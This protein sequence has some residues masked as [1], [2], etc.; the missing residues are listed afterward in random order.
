MLSFVLM[1]IRKLLLE[2]VKLVASD[3]FAFCKVDFI[4][5]WTFCCQLRTTHFVITLA[6]HPFSVVFLILVRT[7]YV[8]VFLKVFLHTRDLSFL[9]NDSLWLFWDHT[10]IGWSL[11]LDLRFLRLG[12]RYGN[13]ACMRILVICLRCCDIYNLCRTA[14][15][16]DATSH[17][18]LVYHWANN[19]LFYSHFMIRQLLICREAVL[20]DICCSNLIWVFLFHL[21]HD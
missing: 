5:V 4:C 8:L 3:T 12:D 19:Y 17:F 1:F 6:A 11:Y 20:K 10:G 13:H 16:S 2:V 18:R 15:L 7:V 14:A 9:L 21:H